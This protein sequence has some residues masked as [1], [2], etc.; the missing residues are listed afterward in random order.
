MP[1]NPN[2][3]NPNRQPD[4]NKQPQPGPKSPQ[5]DPRPPGRDDRPARTES[6]RRGG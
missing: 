1:E 5:K 6:D 4:P 3:N 2:W